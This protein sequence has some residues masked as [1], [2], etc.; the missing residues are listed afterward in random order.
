[1][2]LEIRHSLLHRV[3]QRALPHTHCSAPWSQHRQ[4]APRR[5]ASNKAGPPE[6]RCCGRINDPALCARCPPRQEGARAGQLTPWGRQVVNAWQSS[7][8]NSLGEVW[9]LG[10]GLEGLENAICTWLLQ[11][12]RNE[13]AL[14]TRA[15]G[16]V[17]SSK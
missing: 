5:S 13:T 11:T 12:G 2:A 9:R 10:R 6:H 16:G 4:V 3:S 8:G 14:Q 17:G 7:S 1:M 15:T